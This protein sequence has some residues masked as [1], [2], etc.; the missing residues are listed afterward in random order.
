MSLPG[1]DDLED[2]SYYEPEDMPYVRADAEGG[3]EFD[4]AGTA[5]KGAAGTAP[6]PAKKKSKIVVF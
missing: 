6:A 1:G 4:G 2:D 5:R 3:E